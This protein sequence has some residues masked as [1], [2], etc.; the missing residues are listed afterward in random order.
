MPQMTLKINKTHQ[1]LVCADDNNTFG[2]N[3]H[4]VKEN[5]ESLVAASQDFGLEL[6][7]NAR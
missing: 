1:L 7:Q 5:T 3:V 4:T 6:D 2:R